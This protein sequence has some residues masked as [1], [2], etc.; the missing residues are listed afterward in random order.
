MSNIENNSA[1][2][3]WIK[4]AS[5]DDLEYYVTRSQSQESLIAE[6]SSLISQLRQDIAHLT[7]SLQHA[8]GFFDQ[9]KEIT[10]SN[11]IKP[12]YNAFS[13][14]TTYEMCPFSCSICNSSDNPYEILDFCR[15]TCLY[16][17]RSHEVRYKVIE[18]GI[19][20]QI[21][22]TLNRA[23]PELIPQ[24]DPVVSLDIISPNSTVAS[25]TIV[26][27]TPSDPIIRDHRYIFVT[28]T[29]SPDWGSYEYLKSHLVKNFLKMTPSSTRPIA[30]AYV[31]ENTQ[32][33]TPH[34]HGLIRYGK[35]GI[36]ISESMAI[37]KNEIQL[38]GTKGPINREVGNK[39]I[40]NL[41]VF[42]NRSY[43]T[44][45]SS[46]IEKWEYMQKDNSVGSSICGDPLS[47]FL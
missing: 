7:T 24:P 12:L 11:K 37:Y 6:Q 42:S 10:I 31:I 38:E 9:I 26:Q 36:K 47:S 1:S 17:R 39:T 30:S 18:K 22:K 43:T 35:K 2:F 23:D 4:S 21:R 15:G 8:E 28:L 16:C 46:I 3:D 40:E 5:R 44:N 14:E 27:S 41:S 13:I 19:E 29:A 34:L 25:N 20:R 32:I 45:V 33:G